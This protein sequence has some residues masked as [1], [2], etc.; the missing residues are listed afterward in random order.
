M[1]AILVPVLGR[2]HR[3]QPLLD[4]IA[5]ATPEPYR[6]LFICDPHDELER[7]E[8]A[9]ASTRSTPA[10]R[11]SGTVYGGN[12]AAKINRGV[13]LTDEPLLFLGAD[14]LNFH[15]GWLEVATAKLRWRSS[16]AASVPVGEPYGGS[17]WMPGGNPPWD[18]GAVEG[19]G[20]VGT[21]DLCNE[22]TENGEHSTHSLVARWYTELGTIDDPSKLLHEGYPHEW[23]DDEFIETAKSRGA[24]AH[25][26]AVVEH[27]HPLCGKAPMDHLYKHQ[28]RRMRQGRRIYVQRRPLWTSP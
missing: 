21:R 17:E 1:I 6:V 11:I 23:T 4:S 9:K 2:P 14:D 5:A 18:A 3:V 28:R 8:V 16:P 13:E 20:V 10:R 7:A 25:S 27:L 26:G 12:Y 19:I 24:Y 22:R 15:P